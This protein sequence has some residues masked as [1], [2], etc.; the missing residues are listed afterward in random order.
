MVNHHNEGVLIKPYTN[1]K[2]KLLD[3]SGFVYNIVIFSSMKRE[4]SEP[5]VCYLYT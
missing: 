5:Q 3:R 4:K 1:L 2:E